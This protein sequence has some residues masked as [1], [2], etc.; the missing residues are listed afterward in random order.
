MI[1]SLGNFG[2]EQIHP[3]SPLTTYFTFGPIQPD[4]RVTLKIIYDHRVMDGRCVCA[5]LVALERKLNTAILDELLSSSSLA[6]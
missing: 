4:G 5:A 1:S 3:Q 2:V 6:A